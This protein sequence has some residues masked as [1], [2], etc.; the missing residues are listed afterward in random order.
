[1][2][3]YQADSLEQQIAGHMM[4]PPPKPSASDPK[5]GAFDDVIAT[6]MAK[7]PDQAVPDRGPAG[8]RCATGADRTGAEGAFH[9]HQRTAFRARADRSPSHAVADAAV[10]ISVGC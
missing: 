3:P 9:P 6:G 4:S 1:M 10:S 2:R 7:K 8:G 5:L